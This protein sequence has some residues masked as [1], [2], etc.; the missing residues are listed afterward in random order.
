MLLAKLLQVHQPIDNLLSNLWS[1]RPFVVDSPTCQPN[2]GNGV[3]VYH[4]P[5]PQ[6]AKYRTDGVFVTFLGEGSAAR[7]FR[8]QEGPVDYGGEC[9][10][11]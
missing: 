9:P 7:L 10:L 6:T 3:N 1:Y 2:I 4:F 8:V 11:V 5:L